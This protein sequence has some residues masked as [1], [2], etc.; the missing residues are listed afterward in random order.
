MIR[1]LEAWCE[2]ALMAA[3]AIFGEFVYIVLV[4]VS[5][6]TLFAIEAAVRLI[7]RMVAV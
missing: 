2:R 1:Y 4:L 7:V 3:C 6:A 5:F